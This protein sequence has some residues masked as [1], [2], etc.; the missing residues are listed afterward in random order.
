MKSIVYLTHAALEL[1][2]PRVQQVSARHK[3]ALVPRAFIYSVSLHP[4]SSSGAES[5]MEKKKMAEA[6]KNL[7]PLPPT[8]NC[9]VPDGGRFAGG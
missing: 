8:S 5:G 1:Y 7:P 3:D 9:I 6:V 2:T 4:L